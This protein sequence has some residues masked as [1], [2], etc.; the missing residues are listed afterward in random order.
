MGNKLRP[1]KIRGKLRPVTGCKRNQKNQTEKRAAFDTGN[2]FLK[3]SFLPLTTDEF[4][5]M[6]NREKIEDDFF[7]SL[8]NLAALYKFE[9]A[10]VS[11]T[12]FPY[13]I[14]LALSH[15]A[16][17]LKKKDQETEL[18]VVADDTHTACMATI[19]TFDI[20]RTLYYI[21]VRPLIVLL[22]DKTKKKTSGLLL[23]IFSWLYRVVEIPFHTNPSAYLY[24]CYECLREWVFQNDEDWEDDALAERVTLL[25][26]IFQKGKKME[27]RLGASCH[28][29]EFEKRAK[30]FC[31]K[32]EPE[33]QL[34]SAAT[35]CLALYQQNPY[36]S[37][38]QHINEPLNDPLEED[39]ITPDCYLSFFWDTEDQLYDELIDYINT[40][41]QEKTAMDEPVSIQLFDTTQK[42]ICHDLSFEQSLFP[43]IDQLITI[44][45]KIV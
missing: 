21:P 39:R 15:A 9:P 41:L 36:R 10:D 35:D 2:G 5:I 45:N 38:F 11:L 43:L 40:D 8:M 20:G 27:K 1:R 26:D 14:H 3:H 24:C 6:G 18:I 23:S 13:N 34:L 12:P 16:E 4:S 25:Q 31:P 32:N 29:K 42:D 19:K 33:K 37:I 28:L 17:T 22:T 7:P 30:E 44:L